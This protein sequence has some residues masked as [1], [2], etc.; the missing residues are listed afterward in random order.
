VNEAPGGGLM[1]GS[2]TWLSNCF[3]DVKKSFTFG[4]K[5]NKNSF[6]IFN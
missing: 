1:S 6:Y 4:V 3:A 2:K 5:M